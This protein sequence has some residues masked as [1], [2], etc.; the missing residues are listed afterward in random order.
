MEGVGDSRRCPHVSA[1]WRRSNTKR[2]TAAAEFS[3]GDRCESARLARVSYQDDPV[4]YEQRLRAK[5]NLR[6]ERGFTLQTVFGF[7]YRLESMGGMT[8]EA[9]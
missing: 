1:A 3:G 6:P 2:C 7:G 8:G 9:A 5:L 4:G